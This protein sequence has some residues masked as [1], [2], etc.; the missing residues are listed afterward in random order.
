MRLLRFYAEDGDREFHGATRQERHAFF[1]LSSGAATS[2]STPGN[3]KL[4]F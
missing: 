2:F 3:R 4:S 1:H